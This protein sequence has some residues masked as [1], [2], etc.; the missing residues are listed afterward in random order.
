V[1]ST[2]A[3]INLGLLKYPLIHPPVYYYW[4]AAPLPDLAPLLD[5]GETVPFSVYLTEPD[6]VRPTEQIQRETVWSRQPFSDRS[7]AWLQG[8][9]EQPAVIYD[10]Q[11]QFSQ[12]FPGGPDLDPLLADWRY[13]L[14][15]WTGEDIVARSACPYDGPSLEDLLARRQIEVWLLGYRVTG[16]Q[17]L[18]K[19]AIEYDQSALCNP[20]ERTCVER[21]GY[22]FALHVTP[23]TGYQIIRFPGVE[24]VMAVHLIDQK[25]QELL[26]LPQ[27]E[28]YPWK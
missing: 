18:D 8:W 4:T 12:S 26:E 23:A 10:S 5:N 16:V 1:S 13:L 14:G 19:E 24:D 3:K 21:P 20:A 25:G 6:W 27:R 2:E 15:L 22:H 28:P 11:D 9:F 7:E 17:R